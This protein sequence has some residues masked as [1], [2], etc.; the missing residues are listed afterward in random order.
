MTVVSLVPEAVTR[1]CSV[2][3][4]VIEIL[5]NS[6]EN[7]WNFIKKETLAQVFSYELYEISKSTFSY[8]TFP[9][10]ASLVHQ[11]PQSSWNPKIN[12]GL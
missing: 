3:K 1:R 7:T 6:Q 8:G 4:V 9:Q 10:A 12:F 2:K 11:H 5:Q